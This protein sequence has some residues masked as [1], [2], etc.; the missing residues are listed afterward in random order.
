M[1]IL[2][3]LTG[4]V[5]AVKAVDL[6][7]SLSKLGEVRVVST[8][9]SQ[10]FP[11]PDALSALTTVY[12]DEKEWHQWKKMGDGVLHIDLRK[13]AD[14]FVIAPLSANT[15][16]KISHG[17][18]DNLLTSV[19]RAWDY[20]KPMILAPAMNTM[21]W[22][23]DLTAKQTG[24]M[25]RLGAR[26]VPPQWKKLACGDVGMGAMAPIEKIIE[27][28]KDAT[29]WEWP[30]HAGQCRGIPLGNHP[31][32]FGFTRKF[33]VHTGVD[34]YTFNGADVK[35][36]EYGQVVKIIPFTGSKVFGKDGKPMDWWLDTDAVLVKGASGVI[37]YGEVK[38][39]EGLKVGDYVRPGEIIAKVK[40]VLKDDH[41]KFESRRKIPGHSQSMLHIELY[42]EAYE[43]L[44]RWVWEGWEVGQPKPDKLLDPT[45]R[46]LRADVSGYVD[47]L[48]V[49]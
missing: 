5:A 22:D 1:N 20:A 44:E 2:L 13:W 38:V 39:R 9:F 14:V 29:I 16:S 7:E 47:R 10:Y 34:L 11:G 32:A 31:G 43:N 6:Y 4:S 24:E 36:M 25:R 35:A 48:R 41:E 3:G 49:P 19:A 12:N 46:L 42:S 8:K 30:L 27:E 28:I 23:H 18:A 40:Q 21:M 17:M 45:D 33:D 26:V 37:V 15:L